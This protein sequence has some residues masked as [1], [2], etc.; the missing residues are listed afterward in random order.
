MT[1]ITNP[2]VNHLLHKN[3][4]PS[5]LLSIDVFRAVTM[6]FMIFVNDVD[7][8]EN[9]PEWIKHVSA[10]ADGLG[11]ADTIFPAFLFIVG[12]SLPFAI[13]KR[14]NSGDSFFSVTLYI[15]TR[16]L[17]LLVMGFL[18]VN[19]ENY[20]DAAILPKAVWE[21]L[22]T[23][24]FFFIWLDYPKEIQKT[25]RY[26][27][28]IIGILLLLVMGYLFKGGTV[29]APEGLKPHW[30][31]IL[32]II[33]WAYLV[34]ALLFL[35][36]NG[37]IIMQFIFLAIFFIINIASHTGVLKISIPVIGNA[38]STA[39]TMAG[40]VITLLYTTLAK[41]GKNKLVWL[42]FAAIGITMIVS[43]L[44]IRPYAEGISK[45]RATPA[46]IFICIGISTLVFELMIYLVDIKGNPHWFKA[47]RPAGT[48]TLTCYLIPYLLYSLYVLIGFRY[49]DFLSQG[50]GGIIRSFA[51]SF[52]VI[53][54]AGLL[55]KKKL[56]LKI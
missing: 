18:H 25:T 39:L 10:K 29:D 27:L 33:G 13:K 21:I 45:I 42:L 54:I 30:W 17:A 55:E 12:L 15:L 26:F 47:I 51:V 50:I 52:V 9:I 2:T 20:S 37:K 3:K 46:W 35:L 11:F 49:P 22:I 8:V 4:L 24:S 41:Q 38:A 44:L 48:S 1:S 32:G 19:L 43:G 53:W 36:S 7:G 31:G 14:L 34:C 23:I 5:R 16:S 40:V 56:R 28:Q 6:F